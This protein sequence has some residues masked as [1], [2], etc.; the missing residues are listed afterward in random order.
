MIITEDVEN[1][2]HETENL[3]VC[4]VLRRWRASLLNRKQEILKEE[5][6]KEKQEK[7]LSE[8]M[9]MQVTKDK[10]QVK[11]MGPSNSLTSMSYIEKLTQNLPD[12][13]NNLKILSLV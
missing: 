12:G 2:R 6:K 10:I 7:S 8:D 9:N 5:K 11:L 13:I 3:E 4:S 1:I